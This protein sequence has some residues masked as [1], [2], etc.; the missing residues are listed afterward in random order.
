MSTNKKGESKN[1]SKGKGKEK[2]KDKSKEKG[3][4]MSKDK[5]KEGTSDTSNV[6]CFLCKEKKSHTRKDCPKFSVTNRVQI[7]SRK[8]DGSP[9]WI[10]SMRSYA[11]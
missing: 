5:P 11:S 7:P 8:T 2:G 6:K 10:K 4:G 9:L 1:K 3:K